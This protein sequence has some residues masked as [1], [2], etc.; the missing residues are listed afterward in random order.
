[1]EMGRLKETPMY[2]AYGD[3]WVS[4]MGQRAFAMTMSAP[5]DVGNLEQ[6]AEYLQRFRGDSA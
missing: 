6:A 3:A 2:K 5:D 1:M 4:N